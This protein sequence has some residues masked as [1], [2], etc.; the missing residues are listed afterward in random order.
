[1]TEPE[2]LLDKIKKVS[3][4]RASLL[5]DHVKSVAKEN[6]RLRSELD[7]AR[8]VP[9]RKMETHRKDLDDVD[10][11]LANVSC[12]TETDDVDMDELPRTRMKNTDGLEEKY[13]KLLDKCRKIQ[14]ERDEMA[15]AARMM[16]EERDTLLEKLHDVAARVDYS[17]KERNENQ[18]AIQFWKDKA[19]TLT[20]ELNTAKK[21][22]TS[23]Q[24]ELGAQK[25]A[26][27]KLV[28]HDHY[29]LYVERTLKLLEEMTG[30]KVT[31]IETSMRSVDDSDDEDE[32]DEDDED[33]E[34]AFDRRMS[35]ISNRR[36]SIRA[37]ASLIKSPETEECLVY[38]CE[39]KGNNGVLNY[40]ISMP[41]KESSGGRCGYT[42]VQHRLI[43]SASP[44]SLPEFL[45]DEM[46]FERTF[47]AAFFRR[48]CSWLAQ[49]T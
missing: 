24:A 16:T 42:P 10:T 49:R 13:Q 14:E 47:L 23:A 17:S 31:G 6:D 4:K 39:H 12:Q 33:E 34:E 45:A 20:V 9:S 27:E 15:L 11:S 8:K 5:E 7:A 3:A 40:A 43:G 18:K 36:K 44:S 25:V 37:D 2:E 28:S 1:M 21:I 30:V 35:I 32:D 22:V 38:K 29:L 46:S 41:T 26:A 19:S 48:A